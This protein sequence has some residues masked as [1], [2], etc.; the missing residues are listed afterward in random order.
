[1]DFSKD[2]TE[3]L[4]GLVAKRQVDLMVMGMDIIANGGI[5][6]DREEGFR[7]RISSLIGAA[8]ELTRRKHPVEFDLTKQHPLVKEMIITAIKKST[9]LN[10]L[11]K[12]RRQLPKPRLRHGRH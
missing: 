9:L 8:E 6:T 5:L 2:R 3:D 11:P 4:A 7:D 10:T 12:P 1:M